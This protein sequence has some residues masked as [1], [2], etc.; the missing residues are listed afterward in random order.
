MEDANNKVK[1]A[2]AR[3]EEIEPRV[4]HVPQTGGAEPKLALA[5]AVQERRV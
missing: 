3:E 5:D 4:R 1:D 2:G